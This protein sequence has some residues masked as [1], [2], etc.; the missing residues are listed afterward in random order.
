MEEKLASPKI[1]RKAY[2]RARIIETLDDLDVAINMWLAGRSRNAAGKVFSA[3]KA[4]LSA[5]VTKN[6]DKLAAD[7]EWYVK[8]GYNAPTHSLKSIS[9]DL[10]KLG[11][12]E[13]GSITN[14]ALLLHDYQYNGF[15]PDFSKYKNKDEVLY[16]L[17]I[18]IKII[19]DNIKKWFE[20]EWDNQLD[21]LYNIVLADFLKIKK[22]K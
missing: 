10:V 15:D 22:E 18:V 2:V 13:V 19:L 16:D 4:L 3:V 20:D 11:Y 14:V 7:N 17:V 1:D 5:L 8:K 6:L 9:I 21:I 12:S